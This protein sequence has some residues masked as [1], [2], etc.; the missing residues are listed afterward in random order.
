MKIFTID[1]CLFAVLIS[2]FISCKKEQPVFP[3]LTGEIS[4]P[5]DGFNCY[6]GDTIIVSG[7]INCDY[8]ILFA[9]VGLIDNNYATA[10]PGTLLGTNA[11]TT[12]SFSQSFILDN[13][14]ASSGDY[15]LK[16]S[17]ISQGQNIELTALRK[18][19]VTAIPRTTLKSY[20]ILGS[21]NNPSLYEFDGTTSTLLNSYNFNFIDLKIDSRY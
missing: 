12:L 17:A 2:I 11:G 13:P 14:Y 18:I 16:I 20:C 6:F 8:P 3:L 21:T 1:L 10:V 9:S 7:T 15:F 19:H 4:T 5:S